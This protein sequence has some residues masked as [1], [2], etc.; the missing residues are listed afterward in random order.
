MGARARH[1]GVGILDAVRH[2]LPGRAASKELT[3]LA[4]NYHPP[5]SEVNFKVNSGLNSRV[6][7]GSEE[8]NCVYVQLV[9]G[10]ISYRIF[11]VHTSSLIEIGNS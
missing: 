6:N 10:A 1:I 3:I 2:S 9:L 11:L 8:K 4:S 5:I 7:F